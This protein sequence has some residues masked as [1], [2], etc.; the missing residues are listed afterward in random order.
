MRF[1]PTDPSQPGNDRFVLSKGH[2]APV[3]YAALAEAGALPVEQLVT[4]R[5]F[6]SAL[7]GHPT[8]RVP[9]VGAATGSLGQGLSVGVGMALNGKYLD[10]LDY[11]VYV[12]LGDGEIAEGGG[13]EAAALA[14]HYRLD[15]LIGIIDVNGLGP[16]QRTMYDHEVSIYQSRFSAFGWHTSVVDGHNLEE[17]IAALDKART[18][19]DQPSMI[20]AKTL[21]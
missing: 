8:P 14:S 7:E 15:N 13:W 11:H 16:S 2:A 1:D 6:T 5:K 21:K 20:V 10:K 9:W 3:L 12:L 4:L 19:K 18:R 17:I